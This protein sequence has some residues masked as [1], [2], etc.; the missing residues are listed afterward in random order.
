MI[1][2]TGAGLAIATAVSIAVTFF[3]AKWIGRRS[4]EQTQEVEAFEA[5]V[6]AYASAIR[7]GRAFS[8]ADKGLTPEAQAQGLIVGWI[9]N[10][11]PYDLELAL[12]TLFE[13]GRYYLDPHCPEC[14]SARCMKGHE[15]RNYC[16]VPEHMDD[17]LDDEGQLRDPSKLH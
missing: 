9:G 8:L 7:E 6:R 15:G 3:I 11:I 14:G 2:D 1:I 12:E 16:H 17:I 5:Q 4:H 13:D 10:E